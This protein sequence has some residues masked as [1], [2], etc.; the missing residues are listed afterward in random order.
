MTA[1][2]AVAA[3][4]ARIE[5]LMQD[6]C[7]VTRPGT[8]SGDLSPGTLRRAV[9]VPVII[10]AGKCRLHATRVQASAVEAAGNVA[11]IEETI[12]SIPSDAPSVQTKDT[13]ELT[14][15]IHD[16]N[17]GQRYNINSVLMNTHRTAQRCRV[18]AIIG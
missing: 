4:R 15:S 1:E 8:V 17:A 7:I 14:S 16:F 12:F 5:S 10:Y 2:Y 18:E 11:L 3:G 6:T 13:V 9:N